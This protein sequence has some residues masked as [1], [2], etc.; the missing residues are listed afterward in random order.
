MYIR[1][2]RRVI[3]IFIFS[4]NLTN[5][6]RRL[7]KKFD[8]LSYVY[9]RLIDCISNKTRN[10]NDFKCIQVLIEDVLRLAN[11]TLI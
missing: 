10:K 3:N 7:F 8:S 1:I 5:Y 6:F 4:Y 9:N 11:K 2:S